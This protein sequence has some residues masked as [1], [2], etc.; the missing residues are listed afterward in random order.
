MFKIKK[1]TSTYPLLSPQIGAICNLFEMMFL[2]FSLETK[3]N[4]IIII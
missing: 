2:F 1:E 3:I 4:I